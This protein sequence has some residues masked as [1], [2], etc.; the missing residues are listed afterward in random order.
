MSLISSNSSKVE[1]NSIPQ[2]SK[3]ITSKKQVSPCKLWCFTWNNYDE[4][5]YSSIVPEF[6]KKNCVQY[7]YAREVGESGTP[8][9]Q[10]AFVLK[11]KMRVKSLSD[12]LNKVHFEKMR[13]TI[14]QAF[15]YCRKQDPDYVE[16][17]DIPKEYDGSDLINY[18][19]MYDWQKELTDLCL[20]K[21]D[22][23]TIHWYYCINGNS[24]KSGWCKYMCFHH[25][26]VLISGGKKADVHNRV[27]NSKHKDIFIMDVPRS[28]KSVSYNAIED[29]KNGNVVNDKYETGSVM[30]SPPHIV[31]LANFYPDL[32]LVSSDRW[33][34]VNI[35]NDDDSYNNAQAAWPIGY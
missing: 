3:E 28:S 15:E 35:N 23:R 33:H 20:S 14:K 5:D 19:I 11:T 9:I 21:P 10:G 6:L 17:S 8:H 7:I 16:V 12:M 31:I 27:Y 26:A 18:D 29:I 30:F 34:I 4:L 24:G 32:S 25:N 2:P 1:G 13:G 22:H